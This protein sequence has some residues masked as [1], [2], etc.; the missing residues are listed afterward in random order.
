MFARSV[1]A[2]IFCGGGASSHLG[3][4]GDP[5]ACPG[6]WAP[7]PLPP[8]A[9]RPHT[10]RPRP[11]PGLR[12]AAPSGHQVPT[13]GCC[14]P[15][16]ASGRGWWRG[17]WLRDHLTASLRLL[18]PFPP[19]WPEV[20]RHREVGATSVAPSIRP[21]ERRLSSPGPAELLFIPTPSRLAVTAASVA[22]PDGHA[23]RAVV[24]AAQL[25]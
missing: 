14:A 2:G 15:A 19:Q 23:P 6:A 20:W 22:S 13:V 7:C 12:F 16:L 9:A 8:M 3:K 4:A 25:V 18:L 21:P 11:H 1:A 17:W 5:G 24:A 10:Q